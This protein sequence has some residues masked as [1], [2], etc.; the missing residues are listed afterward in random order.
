LGGPSRGRLAPPEQDVPQLIVGEQEVRR[1]GLGLG[2]AEQL[3]PELGR[4][5]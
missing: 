4:R 2:Q 1:V 3:L 5:L